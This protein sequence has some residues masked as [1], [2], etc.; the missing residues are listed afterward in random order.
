[1]EAMEARVGAHHWV[2]GILSRWIQQVKARHGF[3]TTM[4]TLANKMIRI[5]W[6]LL[7]RGE[8]YC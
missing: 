2:R 7:A 1:M 3:N 4:V 5:A 6:A 8:H